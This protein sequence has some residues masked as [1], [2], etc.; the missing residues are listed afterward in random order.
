ML[1]RSRFVK[2]VALAPFKGLNQAG[3]YATLS[4]VPMPEQSEKRRTDGDRL[5]GPPPTTSKEARRNAWLAR[6][7]NHTLPPRSA[8]YAS[9]LVDLPSKPASMP[10][11]PRLEELSPV[12]LTPGL[13]RRSGQAPWLPDGTPTR[14]VSGKPGKL[15]PQTSVTSSASTKTLQKQLSRVSGTRANIDTSTLA[16]VIPS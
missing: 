14:L 6:E 8:S 1:F 3:R 4:T 2:D 12:K 15:P 5:L 16:A 7:K 11:L 13:G 10:A 9:G